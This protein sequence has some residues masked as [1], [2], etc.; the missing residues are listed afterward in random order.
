MNAAKVKD[1]TDKTSRP[2]AVM[3]SSQL[4][5]N[6]SRGKYPEVFCGGNVWE[7]YPVGSRLGAFS[8]RGLFFYKVRNRIWQ[9]IQEELSNVGVHIPMQDYKSLSAAVVTWATLIKTQYRQTDQSAVFPNKQICHSMGITL[10]QFHYLFLLHRISMAKQLH[11][12]HVAGQIHCLNLM[13]RF[14]I[15]LSTP[16]FLA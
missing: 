15:H 14:L 3:F 6:S 7:K 9:N 12:V 1:K 10:R 16:L 2:S 13:L 11:G 4:R 5:G 8:G